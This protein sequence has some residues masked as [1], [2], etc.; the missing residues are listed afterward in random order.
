MPGPLTAVTQLG[1]ILGASGCSPWSAGHPGPYA[2][3]PRSGGSTGVVGVCPSGITHLPRA[4]LLPCPRRHSPH[5]HDW[6]ITLSTSQLG[7]ASPALGTAATRRQPSGGLAPSPLSQGRAPPHRILH[8]GVSSSSPCC[9]CLTPPSPAYS[10]PPVAV[11]WSSCGYTWWDISPLHLPSL[12][13]NLSSVKALNTSNTLAPQTCPAGSTLRAPDPVPNSLLHVSARMAGRCLTGKH[14]PQ[15][16]TSPPPAGPAP[17]RL[18]NS[19][20][21]NSI[22]LAAQTKILRVILGSPLSP[23]QHLM[24]ANPADP[25]NLPARCVPSVA[26]SYHLLI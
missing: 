10:H 17:A 18:P 25:A 24:S 19:G 23:T 22:L 5:G 14:P 11:P 26:T 21:D 3:S 4:S 12:L 8:T 20:N 1:P 13:G 15:L 16:L 7:A 2:T 6:P 9:S